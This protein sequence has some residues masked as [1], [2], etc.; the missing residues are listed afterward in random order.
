[1]NQKAVEA[2]AD[3]EP[4]LAGVPSC[5]F[6]FTEALLKPPWI[7]LIPVSVFTAFALGCFQL[8]TV[9]LSLGTTFDFGKSLNAKTYDQVI[10]E[11]PALIANPFAVLIR[12]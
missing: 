7:F 6:V 2:K 1:M 9:H 4:A 8:G 3:R 5:Y 10:E 11:F 12:F